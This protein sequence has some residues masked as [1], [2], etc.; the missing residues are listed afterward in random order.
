MN[1]Q[2][3]DIRNDNVK[4]PKVKRT[5]NCW[6]HLAIDRVLFA[7]LVP[8]KELASAEFQPRALALDRTKVPR[9]PIYNRLKRTSKSDRSE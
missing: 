1:H 4:R 5:W 2:K 9:R 8:G 6:S 3:I 7:A